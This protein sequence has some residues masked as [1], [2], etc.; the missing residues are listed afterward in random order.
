MEWDNFEEV[1]RKLKRYNQEHLLEYYNNIQDENLKLKFE[2]QLKK[3]DYE[4]IDSLYKK[5]TIPIKEEVGNVEPIDYWDKERLGGKYDFYEN[6]GIEAIKAGKLAAV[7]MA[8]GQGTRLGHDGPKGSFDIGLDSHKSL[9]EL[10]CDGLK[11]MEKK[12]GVEIP[13]FIMTSEENNEETI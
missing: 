4:L 9:F 1:E 5:T 8:G 7:T 3:I 11:E 10:L 13:W 6:I 2:N 12:Y